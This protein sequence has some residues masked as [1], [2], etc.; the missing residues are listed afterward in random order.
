MNG[1]APTH[2]EE[3]ATAPVGEPAREIAK[4][5]VKVAVMAI[6]GE[7]VLVLVEILALVAAKVIAGACL[8]KVKDCSWCQSCFWP[9]LHSSVSLHTARSMSY[10]EE[11]NW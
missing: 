9:C 4:A 7:H 6:A 3:V 10:N 2:A 8:A 5:V 11:D 1:D